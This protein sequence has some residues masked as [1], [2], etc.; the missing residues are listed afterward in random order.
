MVG[1]RV[2]V[3]LL[4]HSTYTHTTATLVHIHI[5]VLRLQWEGSGGRTT[6]TTSSLCYLNFAPHTHM[7]TRH[8]SLSPHAAIA[9]W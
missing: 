8:S 7:C 2:G 1:G 5:P 9:W 3:L 4:V 6:F